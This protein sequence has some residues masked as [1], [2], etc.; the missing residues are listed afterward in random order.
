MNTIASAPP[1]FANTRLPAN[2]SLQT[3]PMLA[4]MA[5]PYYQTTPQNVPSW[6]PPSAPPVGMTFASPAGD[7][8]TRQAATMRP[9]LS[10]AP[11]AYTMTPGMTLP[12]VPPGSGL[13]GMPLQGHSRCCR[14][15][16]P[17]SAAQ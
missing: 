5:N 14:P 1:P 7:R 17:H 9:D 10:G 12:G 3:Q 8:Y 6:M 16:H 13:W 4:G 15:A 11:N 2:A